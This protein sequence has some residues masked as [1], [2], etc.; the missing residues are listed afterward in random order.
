MELA[1]SKNVI[2]DKWGQLI[3]IYDIFRHYMKKFILLL[4]ALNDRYRYDQ[5]GKVVSH[6]YYFH[7]A[8]K[9]FVAGGFVISGEGAKV[10]FMHVGK[11]VSIVVL[12]EG[13]YR[14]G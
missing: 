12:R 7:T 6:D 4:L 8:G 2:K 10:D 11:L 14:S 9:I 3:L 13:G 5:S 1:V